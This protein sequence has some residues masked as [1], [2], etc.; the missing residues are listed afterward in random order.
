MRATLREIRAKTG[1]PVAF[2]G[3]VGPRIMRLEGGI[4]LRTGAL[5]G[6]DVRTG[7]GLGGRV[8]DTGRAAAVV[9]YCA[10]SGITSEYRSNVAAEGLRSMIAVPLMVDNRLKAVFYGADH[11]A[12]TFGDGVRRSVAN[13][14]RGLSDEL[15]IRREVNRRVQYAEAAAVEHAPGGVAG[16]DREMLRELYSELRMIAG[17]IGDQS[18]R[19]R[20]EGACGQLADISRSDPMMSSAG[21]GGTVLTHMRAAPLLSVR[22][23]DVLAQVALGCTNIETAQRLSLKPETV[24]AYLRNAGQK[25]GTRTRFESVTRARSL[26]ILP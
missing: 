23:I 4:G 24:K 1:L 9:D 22:E 25:L 12:V 20:L 15:R 6:L 17:Q 13:A 26:G 21:D 5:K 10:S 7:S 14:V 16:T 18:V 19:D 3:I 8:V 2:L 11:S